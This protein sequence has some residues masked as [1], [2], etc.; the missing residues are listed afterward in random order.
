MCGILGNLIKIKNLFLIH[1]G[2]IENI[3]DSLLDNLRSKFPNIVFEDIMGFTRFHGICMDDIKKEYTSSQR[4]YIL[5]ERY[6]NKT[7]TDHLDLDLIA[8]EF[9]N[10]IYIFNFND[11]SISRV[12]V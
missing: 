1:K 7:Y 11:N 8:I 9:L 12:F 5:Y 4:F 2:G 10:G 6:T 3:M